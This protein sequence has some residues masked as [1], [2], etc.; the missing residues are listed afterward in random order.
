LNNSTEL[1]AEMC[2][3]VVG[4]RQCPL[5]ALNGHPHRSQQSEEARRLWQQQVKKRNWARAARVSS[6][7]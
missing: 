4:A 7:S 1:H 6:C 5:L 3:A 2:A